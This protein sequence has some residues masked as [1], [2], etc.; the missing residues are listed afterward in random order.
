M[1]FSLTSVQRTALRAALINRLVVLCFGAG[2]DSAAMLVA[3]RLAGLRPDA[4]TFADA[5]GEKPPTLAHITRIEHV[6]RA[7]GWP[8]IETCRKLTQPGTPYNDLQGNCLAN[9]TLPSLA[10]GMKSCSIKWKQQPQNQHLMGVVRGPNAKC[11]P[12]ASCNPSR[13][14]GASALRTMANSRAGP[15]ASTCSTSARSGAA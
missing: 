7:W 11:A 4:I 15:R 1:S 13:P 8:P 14:D 10:F 9:E 12:R 2:V 6:L 5:G 3:R